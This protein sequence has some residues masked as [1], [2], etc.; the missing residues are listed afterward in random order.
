MI[1]KKF[2]K[3]VPRPKVFCQKVPNSKVSGYTWC[4]NHPGRLKSQETNALNQDQDTGLSLHCLNRDLDKEVK[5]CKS[6]TNVEYNLLMVKH[7]HK[8]LAQNIFCIQ[9]FDKKG[10]CCNV[11]FPT[12]S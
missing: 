6:I 3:K 10:L 9:K 7:L 1:Q 12:S 2:V 5:K 11:N 8:I 4:S